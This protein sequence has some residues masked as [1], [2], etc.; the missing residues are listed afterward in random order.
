MYVIVGAQRSG[1]TYLSKIIDEHPEICLAKPIK[2]EPKF[3]L[4]EEYEL[5]KEFYFKKYF[6]QKN[7]SIKSFVEKSTSYYEFEIVPKRI[8]NLFPNAKIIF[9][10]RNP[11]QRALSNY[12]FSKNNGLETRS[13]EEVFLLEKKAP[14]YNSEISTNPFNYLQRGEYAKYIEIYYKYFDTKDVKILFFNDLIGNKEKIKELYCFL[15]VN[16]NFIPA[17]FDKKINNSKREENISDE[18]IKTIEEYYIKH[19][20]NLQKLMGLERLEW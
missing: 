14:K 1:T 10:L 2:P 12:F 17:S 15:E 8:K 6:S 9:L 3:F 11:V 13:L 19:N 4:R 7:N 5:G 18:I 16:D 20:E